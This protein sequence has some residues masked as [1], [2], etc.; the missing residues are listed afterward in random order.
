MARHHHQQ[1]QQ[2]Q[3][4][5]QSP[6]HPR[7]SSHLPV[8]YN[9]LLNC[10]FNN[11]NH[12]KHPFARTID[13]L[14]NKHNI[15]TILVPA[16]YVLNEFHDPVTDDSS[17]K[18][19]LKDLCYNNEDFIKSHIIKTGAP[20]S[21]TMTPNSKEQSVIYNTMNGKQ[22]LIK[23]Q[24]VYTGK[25]FKRSL[26][27]KITSI[28]YF[29]SFCDYFPKGS[30]FMII[31]LES[32]L[33]GGSPPFKLLPSTPPT[34]TTSTERSTEDVDNVTFEKLLR[35][36]PLLSKAVG[37]KFYRL[38]HHNN[39]QFHQL[40]TRTRKQLSHIRSEF[41]KMQEE[42]Y[43][44]ISDSVREENP[45]REQ[46]YNLL[47]HIISTYPELDLNKLVHEYVELNLYDLMWSQLIYQFNCPNNDKL[48]YDPDAM[49]HLTSTEY[50][51]L[52]CLSLNQLDLPVN[53]PWL[54][55][56]LH[57]RVYLAI[58]EFKKLSDPS[59][60]NSTMKTNIVYKTMEI[61]SQSKE[62]SEL[63]IDADSLIGLLIMTVVHS[64]IDNIEAHIYYIN[65]FNAVDRNNDGHFSYMM[66]NLDAV[67]CHLS[68]RDT[69]LNSLA[70]SSQENFDLWSGIVDSDVA[71]VERIIARTDQEYRDL[72]LP[73]KHC[74]LSKNINGESSL[75]FTI[76]ARNFEIYNMILNTSLSWFSIDYILF[77]KNVITNQNLLMTAL[78]EETD[79]RILDDL[80]SI[81]TDNATI[82]EQIAYFNTPDNTGRTVG[83]YLF[84]H[85][86][87]IPKIGHLIDW[88]LKDHNS[89]TP[90]FS[91]CRCY[92]HV[93]Y[94]TLLQD[95]FDVVYK[96]YG[97]KGIDFDKHMDKSG[98]SLLHIILRGIPQTRI[99][100]KDEN[101]VNV[102][103]PNSKNLT[104]L[105]LYV[106]YS[107]LDNLHEILK[108]DRLEFLFEDP[109]SFH[110][111]FDYL[112]FVGAKSSSSQEFKKIE[113]LVVDHYFN[114]FF[115]NSVGKLAAF[116]GRFDSN[117]RE[118]VILLKDKDCKYRAQSVRSIKQALY[119]EKL[120]RPM[121]IFPDVDIIWRNHAMNVPTSFMF[122]RLRV[123]RLLSKLNVILQSVAF[124]NDVDTGQFFNTLL[125]DITQ[126]LSVLEQKQAIS[127]VQESEKR[128]L[129]QVKLKFSNVQEM[130]FFLDFS[131]QDLQRY[132]TLVTKLSKLVCVGEQKQIDLRNVQDLA[133]SRFD[134]QSFFSKGFSIPEYHQQRGSLDSLAQYVVWMSMIDDELT[135]HF[136]KINQDVS[137]WK[138]L[139]H[140]I[141]NI[142]SELRS[143]EP[144]SQSNDFNGSLA[145]ES[146]DQ[147][148]TGEGLHRT[149]T[150][151]SLFSTSS[152]THADFVPDE[153]EGLN[154]FG[155]GSTKRNRYKRMVVSKADLVKQI[156]K[157]NIDLKWEYEIIATQISNFLTFR[158]KFLKFGLSIKDIALSIIGFLKQSV[159]DKT[160][161]EDFVESMDVAIDCIA[162]AFEVN[163]DDDKSVIDSKFHGKSLAELVKA[164]SQ[165]SPASSSSSDTQPS[166]IVVD[167]ATK[168]KADQL[169]LEGN[170]LMGAKDYA[171]AIAKYTEAIGLDPT[172]VVYLSNRA[173]AYSSAQKHA[174]AVEDA[175][176]AIKLNPEF[177]R[178]YSRLGLA[179]YAL[180][181]PKEAMEAY[182]KG[183]EVEGDKPSDG[184]KKGYETAKKRVEQEL[185]NS[186]STSDRSG[187]ESGSRSAPDSG[188]GAGAGAGGLPDFSSMFGGA[189][190]ADGLLGNLMNNPQMMQAAQS[191][192]SNP[193]AMQE[194]LNNPAIRQMAQSL[195]LGGP[196]GPD[197][198]NIMNNP[199]LNQFMGG[200]GNNNNNEG[201]QGGEN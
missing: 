48:E 153:S 54:I 45:N 181:K 10:I 107:R 30:Q 3:P 41:A 15:Y 106:K 44:I 5:P 77:N 129:G 24:M 126:N 95:A 104:P 137:A 138:K 102:N 133:I 39:L 184:M 12:S 92:D 4:Q 177:S 81:I 32:S 193:G 98:N 93:D 164:S 28:S 155:L 185:E 85:H 83:H 7:L 2:R 70:A 84:H 143:M 36:F 34:T 151:S 86:H 64:K 134:G 146:Q 47:N 186:I 37:D 201:G 171:G 79:E 22:V 197:L 178:A 50:E 163:K 55:N 139:Y 78:I 67:I 8:L 31:H 65:N 99:L 25:G 42:A 74:L 127:A 142:N 97:Q 173:A 9:P 175:E 159:A 56:E 113:S 112:S 59:I 18:V 183:L 168:E 130:E 66:S 76:K 200:R 148:E 96:K 135:K 52:S 69:S 154:L 103:L 160:I 192:M 49:K 46:T 144:K 150:N 80:L 119:V 62:G 169:K 111:V 140:E 147:D 11:P 58:Q 156:M 180:G 29:K 179:Q 105:M 100:S 101:L 26:K 13:E 196:D 152:H 166:S 68:E 191:M 60:V 89:H 61:L 35:N 117:S 165:S 114:K 123:N 132:G 63:V 170:R 43:K 21:S 40:R 118:W 187:H 120:Q 90:L 75:D 198:S 124:Y 116:N 82:D 71:K 16:A 53:K 136:H 110:N 195:G 189:G 108:D 94:L 122:Q 20:A 149:R 162:D 174:Q 145:S 109:R 125:G 88:E 161:A 14:K 172:N 158:S 27:L 182:K 167:D 188:A 121:S 128:A 131:L 19:L 141:C 176:K 194:M 199:M 33:I 73:A 51:S 190:G 57:Q 38:F 23:N 115:P 17:T 72:E 1:Q 87:F 91:L 6:L 157:L